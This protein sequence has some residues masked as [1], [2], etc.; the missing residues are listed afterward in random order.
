MGVTKATELQMSME[1]P[2]GENSD[3][4]NARGIAQLR[5]GR[6]RRQQHLKGDMA[7]EDV[8]PSGTKPSL[9]FLVVSRDN[10]NNIK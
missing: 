3:V 6:R 7:E 1:T 10:G 8:V 2:Q 5:V 4:V 9:N